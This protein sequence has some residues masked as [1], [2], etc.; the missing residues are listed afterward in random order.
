M[1]FYFQFPQHLDAPL[2][3]FLERMLAL[4]LKTPNP[5]DPSFTFEESSLLNTLERSYLPPG[6][7]VT[8]AASSP[9][10][11]ADSHSSPRGPNSIAAR[12]GHFN[13]NNANPLNNSRRQ[14]PF[15][16]AVETELRRSSSGEIVG[17]KDVYTIPASVK[18]MPVDIV[19]TPSIKKSIARSLLFSA[20]KSGMIVIK[21]GKARIEF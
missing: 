2:V 16:I 17:Y 9:T 12:M 6:S 10:V 11:P 20:L 15:N 18:Y 19:A 8:S 21:H 5:G 14:R 7:N 13:T 3:T 4:S 1:I